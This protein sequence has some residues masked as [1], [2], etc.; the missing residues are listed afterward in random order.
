[1]D[2]VGTAITKQKQRVMPK[3][4]VKHAVPVVQEKKKKTHGRR[5][6]QLDPDA[7][8]PKEMSFE[9]G[10][11]AMNWEFFKQKFNIY[12][13]SSRMERESDA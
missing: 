5:G 1:M 6:K 3:S 11:L 10:N 9:D 13:M 12:L 4:R 2:A 8:I 7:K